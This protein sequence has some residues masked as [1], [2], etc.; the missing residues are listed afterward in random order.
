MNL[1][2]QSSAAIAATATA[3][4]STV[5]YVAAAPL[6]AVA[7]TVCCAK[8]VAVAA[9]AKV[10]GLGCWPPL[11]DVFPPVHKAHLAID[12][13]PFDEAHQLAEAAASEAAM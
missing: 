8:V 3:S 4:N 6:A 12:F 10:P 7:A 2:V 11:V 1:P 5:A 13:L 9:V